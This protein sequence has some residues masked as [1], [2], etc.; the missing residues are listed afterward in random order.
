MPPVVLRVDV[1]EQVERGVLLYEGFST[2][3][4]LSLWRLYGATT[5]SEPGSERTG[6]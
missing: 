6:T 4:P 5:T 2:N 1:P 3:E